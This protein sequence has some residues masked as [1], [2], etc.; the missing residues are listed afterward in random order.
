MTTD[1]GNYKAFRARLDDVLRRGDPDAL[2]AFLVAEGQWQPGDT[3]NIEA[4]MWMMIATSPALRPLHDEAE[5]WLLTHG[6][7]TE[8][9]AIFGGRRK[10]AAGSTHGGPPPSRPSR[11]SPPLRPQRRN[12]NPAPQSP[13]QRRP[14]DDAPRPPRGRIS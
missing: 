8:A 7:E 4:A 9:S 1:P 5:R 10:P 3:T 2:R 12:R 14:R 13:T 11:P 6:H